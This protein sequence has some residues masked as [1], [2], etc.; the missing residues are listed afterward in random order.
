MT[1]HP[2]S[3]MLEHRKW[4]NVARQRAEQWQYPTNKENLGL[5]QTQQN[6]KSE[7][8]RPDAGLWHYDAQRENGRANTRRQY[9]PSGLTKGTREDRHYLR[10]ALGYYGTYTRGWAPTTQPQ[11]RYRKRWWM[12][13]IYLRQTEWVWLGQHKAQYERTLQQRRVEGDIELALRVYK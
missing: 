3:L 5:H 8:R 12:A 11:P 7:N 10:R 13:Q 4:V 1:D 2:S 9:R 6:K